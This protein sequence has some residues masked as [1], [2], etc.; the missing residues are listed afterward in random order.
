[1]QTTTDTIKSNQTFFGA[2]IRDVEDE[3]PPKILWNKEQYYRLSDLG[4]FNGKRVELLEGEI[5]VKYT[6]KEFDEGEY[7][8]SAMS[9]LHF[10]GVNIVAEVLREVFKE[11][12]FVSVQCPIDMG[13]NSEPE[14]DIS[15]IEGKARDFKEAIPKTASLIVEVSDSSLLY[16]R[17]KKVSLYARANIQDYWILNLKDRR[18]EVYRRPMQN[19]AAFYGFSFGEIH[20]YKE[21]D[22]VSPIAAPDVKIK[23]A[24]LLP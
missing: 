19:E 24:D 18:L 10:S 12:Y 13:E 6:Y 9:S 21:N 1:M 5:Y 17:G 7:E 22:E 14:P 16:D 20:I 15:I 23:V 4:F 2:E 8:M 3:E 11:K